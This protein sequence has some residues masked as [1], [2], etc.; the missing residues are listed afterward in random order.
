MSPCNSFLLLVFLKILYASCSIY[1]RKRE[2]VSIFLSK[3]GHYLLA[4]LDDAHCIIQAN[5]NDINS[6]GS[7]PDLK[8]CS[9]LETS[10]RSFVGSP[11]FAKWKDHDG[12]DGELYD[13]VIHSLERLLRALAKLYEELFDCIRNFQSEEISSDL[14]LS[15]TQLQTSFKNNRCR[16][17][18]MELDVNADSKSVDILAVNGDMASGISCSAVK[19][20]LDMVSL[21]SSFFSVLDV[22]TWD[23]LFELMDKESSQEVCRFATLLSSCGY[24]LS[25]SSQC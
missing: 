10:F 19:W 8:E 21:I 1:F 6:L 14:Y 11:I 17:V 13:S 2:E 24:N 12:P 20:K 18:D 23:I 22:L 9:S 7:N 16:I 5:H 3:A 25:I 15:D 4:L